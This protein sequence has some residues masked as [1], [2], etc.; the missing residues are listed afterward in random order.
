MN[1]DP[2]MVESVTTLSNPSTSQKRLMAKGKSAAII[3]TTVLSILL[4]LSLNLRVDIA[5]TGVSRLGTILSTFF[6]P[7]K[8]VSVTSFKSRSTNE[9]SGALSPTFGKVPSTLMGLPASVT[10]IF[11]LVQRLMNG[12][13]QTYYIVSR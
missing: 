9:K 12:R 2:R 10:M 1:L 11:L 8:F 5:Q 7:A 4:A 13:N 3:S 6:L